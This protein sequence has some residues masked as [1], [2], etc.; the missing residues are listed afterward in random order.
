MLLMM[1]SSFQ[2]RRLSVAAIH[3]V[4]S[5]E[6]LA[7]WTR[8]WTCQSLWSGWEEQ[9]TQGR[10]YRHPTWAITRNAIWASMVGLAHHGSCSLIGGKR[11]P[12]SSRCSTEH[13]PDWS[14]TMMILMMLLS[15]QMQRF[16]FWCYSWC[17][18][19]SKCNVCPL[20]SFTACWSWTP[21]DLNSCLDMPESV[22]ML[23]RT[24]DARKMLPSSDMSHHSQ[25]NLS[26]HGWTCSSW[27][28]L[29]D[30]RQE[31]SRQL[32]MF[33]WT[34][35]RLVSHTDDT[36]D[37]L[38]IPKATFC[39]SLSFT[40]CWAMNALRLE[41]VF[42]HARVCDQVEKN[43]WRKED[44]TVIRHEPSLAM[45]SELPWLDLLIMDLARW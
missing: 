17:S 7:T 44:A 32:S 23:R 6:R 29:V 41:L 30:R 42:G 19:H 43:K 28:L 5:Y 45:Q 25:C 27:I 15:F 40:A 4:L 22:I 21:C 37:V 26:F 8:V 35:S 33:Y 14:V 31:K 3:S 11:S 36:H 9:V 18:R 12:H 34:H 13:I 10:C 1:F 24:S 2:M 20:L 16:V 39:L 38:V